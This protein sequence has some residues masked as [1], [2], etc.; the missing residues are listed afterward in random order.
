MPVK[1]RGPETVGVLMIDFN[2]VV[3]EGLQ[4]ILAK[5]QHIEVTGD[6]SPAAYQT[7]QPAGA[8]CPR[9]ADRDQQ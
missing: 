8:T 4:A 5:D 6:R 9:G 1:Q 2:P 7:S 3:R